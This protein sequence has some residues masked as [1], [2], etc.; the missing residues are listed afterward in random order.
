MDR[1]EIDDKVGYLGI[2]VVNIKFGGLVEGKLFFG[3]KILGV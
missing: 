3:D 2:Y 1:L